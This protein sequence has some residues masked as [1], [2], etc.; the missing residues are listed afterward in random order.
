MLATVSPALALSVAPVT[1]APT[2]RL[3]VPL[4]V[5][6]AVLA[7]VSPALAFSVPPATLAPALRLTVPLALSSCRWRRPGRRWR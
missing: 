1:V 6:V 4:A 2:L 5:R 7:T 3:T